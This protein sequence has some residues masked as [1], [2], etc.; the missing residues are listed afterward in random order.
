[1]VPYRWRHRVSHRGFRTARTGAGR[2]DRRYA[3]RAGQRKM[4]GSGARRPR[5]DAG[6]TSRVASAWA[7]P[8][9]RGGWWRSTGRRRGSCFCRA[10][11]VV[12][13]VPVGIVADEGERT[14]FRSD[15]LSFVQMAEQVNQSLSLAGK[16]PS[17]AFNA[18]FDYRGCWHRD[19]AATR[20]LCFDGRFVEL[21]SV[22]AVRAQLALQDR[23]KQDVPPI[24]GNDVVCVKQLKGSNLTQSDVQARL[25]KL[26]DDKFSQDCTGNS[27][28]GDD[29]FSQGINGNFGPGSAAW[30]SFRSP[31]VS[32][33]DHIVSIHIRRGGA[34]NGQGHS[35]W[36]STITS[37]PDVISMAFVPITATN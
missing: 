8:C 15:V 37:F 29:E 4:R 19:A 11:A 1:M 28:A 2:R 27:T 22:E 26:A 9:R 20:S 36:L 24:G 12:V 35:K 17:G 21:Y 34:D 32:Y 30:H 6:T 23:V 31:V 7:A 10:G 5:S 13:D 3:S 14:R 25:K 16:I 33:K 18:M